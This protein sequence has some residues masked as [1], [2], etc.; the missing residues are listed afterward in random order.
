MKNT[1]R[2]IEDMLPSFV[3]HVK[4]KLISRKIN[5]VL[6]IKIP[7]IEGLLRRASFYFLIKTVDI[8]HKLLIYRI[9]TVD[10]SHK[11]HLFLLST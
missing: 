7:F 2:T 10:I 1:T 9:K 5:A 11:F 8:S 3:I 4:L 6:L